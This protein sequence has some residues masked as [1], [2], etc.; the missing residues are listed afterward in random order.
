MEDYMQEM[1]AVTD[2]RA[3]YDHDKTMA[4]L[5][6]VRDAVLTAIGGRD[7]TDD[8]ELGTTP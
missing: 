5:N 3:A 7:I 8:P 2:K 1:L 6:G 4:L